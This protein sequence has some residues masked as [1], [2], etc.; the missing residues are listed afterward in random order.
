ML[1]FILENGKGNPPNINNI[2]LRYTKRLFTRNI[3]LSWHII[4][5]LWT[6]Q[7]YMMFSASLQNGLFSDIL[8]DFSAR[9]I[10]YIIM[11]F[12]EIWVH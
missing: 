4:L 9:G 5:Q 12:C 1:G 2:I 6:E 8:G 10:R 3:Q 11:A 7:Y